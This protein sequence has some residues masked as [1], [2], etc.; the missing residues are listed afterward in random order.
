MTKE[1]PAIPIKRRKNVKPTNEFTKPV[2]AVGMEAAMRT[3][4][5]GILAPY[6][7]QTAPKTKRMKMSP[8][9]ATML[10]IQISLLLSSRVIRISGSKGAMENQIKNAMKNDHHE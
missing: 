4:P 3:A 10:V 2:Q 8:V 5:I 1:E 7:S 6:L 9:T